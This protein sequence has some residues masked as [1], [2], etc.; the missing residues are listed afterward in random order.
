MWSKRDA[1]RLLFCRNMV[2]S[3]KVW[4]REKTNPF[5]EPAEVILLMFGEGA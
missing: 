2:C 3:I 5:A 1:A 4:F